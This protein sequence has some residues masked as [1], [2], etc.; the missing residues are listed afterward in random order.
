MLRSWPLLLIL[1][2]IYVGW[3]TSQP[4]SDERL[5]VSHAPKMRKKAGVGAKPE[6]PYGS[7]GDYSQAAPGTTI[8]IL[9]A[10]D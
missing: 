5:E 8:D 2:G 10:R 6:S 7:L 1:A 9:A 3:K 4:Q